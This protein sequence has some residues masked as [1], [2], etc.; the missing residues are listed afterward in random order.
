MKK[1][2][3]QDITECLNTTLTEAGFLTRQWAIFKLAIKKNPK[4]KIILWRTCYMIIE[5]FKPGMNRGEWSK[6]GFGWW[7]SD[8][9]NCCVCLW[10]RRY[11][12]KFISNHLAKIC[13][14]SS[15]NLAKTCYISSN[16]LLKSL[17][18]ILLIHNIFKFPILFVRKVTE[19]NDVIS[20]SLIIHSNSKWFIKLVDNKFT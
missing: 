6:T 9:F 12:L 8:N 2:W 17:E 10:D 11:T 4:K 18:M 20:W 13:Y 7:M 19:T 3:A 5:V 15:N 1:W 14:I 16:H